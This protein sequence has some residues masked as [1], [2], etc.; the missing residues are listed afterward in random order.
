MGMD[1]PKPQ[2]THL[3]SA[4]KEKHTELAYIHVVEPRVNG[5]VSQDQP[6]QKSP[7]S[8]DFIRDIWS[9]RPLISAG[10]YTRDTAMKTATE[11]GGLIAFGRMYI[12][13]VSLPAQ[14]LSILKLIFP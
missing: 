4:L 12:S 8:N 5:D 2:F 1:D 6:A 10:G 13:N 9:P 14:V 11:K 7:E 3:V